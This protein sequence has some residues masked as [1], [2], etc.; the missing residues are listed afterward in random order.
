MGNF[1]LISND[2]LN[3]LETSY[4]INS[5]LYYVLLIFYK[6]DSINTN[7]LVYLLMRDKNSS[8]K[9]LMNLSVIYLLS[10]ISCLNLLASKRIYLE[11]TLT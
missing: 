2:K 1:S 9:Y 8:K 6:L 4:L 10:L 11:K 7:L 3:N 5:F